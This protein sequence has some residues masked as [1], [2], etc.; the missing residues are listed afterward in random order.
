MVARLPSEHANGGQ[1]RLLLTLV[2]LISSSDEKD[3]SCEE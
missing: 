3:L 2:T 1:F